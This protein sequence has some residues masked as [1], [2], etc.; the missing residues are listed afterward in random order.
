MKFGTSGLR[1]LAE[2]LLGDAARDHIAAF[3]RHM[4][5]A[6]YLGEAGQIYL[7]RD[8]RDSSPAIRDHCAETLR[9][10]GIQPVDCGILPTPALALAAMAEGVPSIMITGSHI[11]ADRNGIKFYRP[12]G[13]I[14]K[15]DERT[16]QTGAAQG[17]PGG[18][19]TGNSTADAAPPVVDGSAAARRAYMERCQAILP[20]GHLAGW[21]IGIYA[22]SSNARSIL[23]ELLGHC[24]ARTVTLGQ[25]DRFVPVDT[26]AISDETA[27]RLVKWSGAD[28]LDAIVSTDADADR[29]LLADENGRI[30]RG[31]LMGLA[32][33]D[34]LG[35][36]VI[37]T[38]VSSNSGIDDSG[39]A[40]VIRTRI[41]S[42]YVVEQMKAQ[43]EAGAGTVCGFEANGGFL[44]QTAARSPFGDIAALP[45]RDSVLPLLAALASAVRQG[46][47]LSALRG[48]WNF[49]VALSDRL[50]DYP[51]TMANRLVARLA[52]ETDFRAKFLKG[53]GE[54]VSA[55]TTDGV[56]MA[57]SAGGIV[58][59][60]PS[61]NA[62]ELRCYCE[63]ADDTRAQHLL[64]ESLQRAANFLREEA[65]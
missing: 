58:H 8:R 62:P 26:E 55:D 47:P 44:L 25:S 41:G 39:V 52:G 36:D 19:G 23:A 27:G 5:S 14:D 59:F 38:P 12:D 30:I 1:G 24:G 43:A 17:E 53:L 46:E 2:D 6:G 54:P 32:T 51:T 9:R 22:H 64:R 31:D 34:F 20:E 15:D 49:P 50:E 61:G 63:A 29:P 60:R 16:I 57:L 28:D 35:A 21:T 42:P 11:P 10:A 56:R 48:R 4:Q 40:R 65:P 45:T 7:A 33:A 18:P 13:E 3:V 37:V